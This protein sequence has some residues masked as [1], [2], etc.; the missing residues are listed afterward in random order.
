MKPNG[1]LA[2]AYQSI[3]NLEAQIKR[4]KATPGAKW[5]E[6]GEPD[7][8]GKTYECQRAELPLGQLTDDALANAVFLHDHRSLDLQAIL[9][10]AP[11]SIALLTAAKDR[12]RWLS[13]ELTQADLDWRV[14]RGQI[15]NRTHTTVSV[16]QAFHATGP[17]QHLVG[18]SN[19]CEAIAQE[20][21]K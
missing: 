12:I 21:N 16:M 19:W 4:L 11:S 10:G 17:S 6:D 9:A 15:R 18:T 8:H 7:P 5:R 13:R 1:K 20:L 2:F 14:L 3:A